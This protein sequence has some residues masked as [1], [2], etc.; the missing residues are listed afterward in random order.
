MTRGGVF[1]IVRS[2][3]I[4]ENLLLNVTKLSMV[5]MAKLLRYLI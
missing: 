3:E 5:D 4:D 1:A 2:P